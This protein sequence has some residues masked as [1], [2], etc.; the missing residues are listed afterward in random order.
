V[1]KLLK[2][3]LWGDKTPVKHTVVG[4]SIHT[5]YVTT[6]AQV[7]E[8]V[9]RPD[10]QNPATFL[11]QANGVTVGRVWVEDNGLSLGVSDLISPIKFVN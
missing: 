7:M 9:V 10:P 2:W 6:K 11:V 1:L 5:T 3:I 4:T 8:I